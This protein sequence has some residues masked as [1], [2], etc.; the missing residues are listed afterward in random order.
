MARPV[1]VTLRPRGQITLPP[2]I[3]A[4]L[5]VDAGD[6]IQLDITDKGV[7]MHGLKLIPADQAW[8]WTTEWQ[9]GEQEADEQA[10]AGQGT[11]FS[12]A[13]EMFDALGTKPE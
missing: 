4:A 10:A 11:Y 12:T 7:F 6:E 8:F 1:R 9:E 5:H 3:R 2:E 13:E